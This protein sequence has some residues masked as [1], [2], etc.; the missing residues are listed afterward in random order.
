[1]TS[2]ETTKQLAQQLI[3]LIWNEGR[4]DEAEALV[5]ADFVNHGAP[6]GAPADRAAFLRAAAT[7]RTVFPDFRV[8]VEDL[9]AEGE[10]VVAHFTAHGTHREAW[11]HPIIGRIAARGRPVHWRGVRLFRIAGGRATATWVYTDSLGLLQQL[12]ALPGLAESVG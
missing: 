12:G 1:M 3:D 9:V 5:A 6:P 7:T 8:T 2:T 4:L 11:E 10:V